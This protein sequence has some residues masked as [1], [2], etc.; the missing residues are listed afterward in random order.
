MAREKNLARNIAKPFLLFNNLIILNFPLLSKA[1]F[2]WG[3][4]IRFDPALIFHFSFDG[5]CWSGQLC[6][7]NYHT[8]TV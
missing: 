1:L 8:S 6:S 4:F 3:S 7:S 5:H 2:F